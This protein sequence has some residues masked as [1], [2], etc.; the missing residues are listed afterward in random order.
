MYCGSDIGRAYRIHRKCTKLGP[1]YSPL[2]IFSPKA[3][4]NR[5]SL[6]WFLPFLS[7][8]RTGRLYSKLTL[9]GISGRANK[10]SSG[11][12]L[13]TVI[14]MM[15]GLPPLPPDVVKLTG[16]LYLGSVLNWALFGVLSVQT[17]LYYLGFPKDR[18][19]PKALV[20]FVYVFEALQTILS[21][22]DWWRYFGSGWGN[23]VD[24]DTIGILW[25]SGPVMTIILS[26][27]VQFFF[28]WR[29][30]IIGRSPYFPILTILLSLFQAAGGIWT[31]VRA[32]QLGHWTLLGG[33]A[34]VPGSIW[35]AGTA[36]CDVVITTAMFY[37]LN[38]SKTGFRATNTILVKFIRLT[39]ET[40]LIT[41]TFAIIDLSL[42]LTFP[43]DNYHLVPSTCLSKLYSNSLMVLLNARIRIQNGRSIGYSTTDATLSWHASSQSDAPKRSNFS[44]SRVMDVSMD[45]T[46]LDMEM[47]AA[48][49]KSEENEL[50][51]YGSR[52]RL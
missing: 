30:W 27:P 41:T 46:T 26:C 4:I 21:M 34:Q 48:K 13:F 32:A 17:Y 3:F 20:A 1:M 2:V 6:P 12:F 31:G 43:R 45:T 10:R 7:K 39:V 24:F 49:P 19:I 9:S 29:M 33:E 15:S 14:A 25:F 52:T 40:G 50:V 28:A 37:Y 11:L 22:V 23:I 38:K 16:P 42:Y 36:A 51:Y 8:T 44:S 18:W 5:L 47:S 35:L